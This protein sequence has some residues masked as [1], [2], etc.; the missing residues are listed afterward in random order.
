MIPAAGANVGQP[1]HTNTFFKEKFIAYIIMTIIFLL[2]K[3]RKDRK[4]YLYFFV[5]DFPAFFVSTRTLSFYVHM[6]LRDPQNEQ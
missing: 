4:S 6:D 2:R 1:R 5:F 3:R